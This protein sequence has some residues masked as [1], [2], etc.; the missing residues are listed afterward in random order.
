[1]PAPSVEQSV[2]ER[3]LLSVVIPTYNE[4][5][6]VPRVYERLNAVLGRLDV[7]AE[8]IFSVDPSTDRTEHAIRELNALDPRVKMLRFSRRFGQPAATL[9]G[10]H[11]AAGDACVVI[12][13]D[14]ASFSLR[15]GPSPC[16]SSRPTR[17]GRDR[18]I[19][20]SRRGRGNPSGA[21]GRG[22]PRT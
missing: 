17:S 18:F 16:A 4:E 22:A 13:C 7:D 1:M 11:V 21:R 6:N 14:P 12:D 9:A 20:P 5:A 15:D 8:I 2:P 3:A 19:G 10:M